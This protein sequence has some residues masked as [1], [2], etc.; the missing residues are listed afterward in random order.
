MC[1]LI[2]IR[3]YEQAR[4][5]AKPGRARPAGRNVRL[6]RGLVLIGVLSAELMRR[7]IHGR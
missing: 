6:S 1:K 4:R 2:E 5:A 3:R 7:L